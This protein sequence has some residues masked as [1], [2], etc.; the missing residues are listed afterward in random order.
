MIGIVMSGG[1][2]RGGHTVGALEYM[3]EVGVIPGDHAA[4]VGG[5]SHGALAAASLGQFRSFKEGVAYL[6][7]THE[8]LTGT[9]SI[10]RYR[11]P[12]GIPS[13]WNPSVGIAE[14]A[15][16]MIRERIQPK[17]FEDSGVHV[18]C[19]AVDLLSGKLVTY[20]NRRDWKPYY[21]SASFP[22]FFE[23]ISIGEYWLTDGGLR[24]V[25][26]LGA[27]IAAGCTT[28]YVLTC[29]HPDGV[30]RLTRKELRSAP[31]VAMRCVEIM[32]NEILHNDIKLCKRVNDDVRKGF[33]P[34]KRTVKLIEIYP[35]QPLGD[36]LDF[37]PDLFAQRRKLGY[38]D[39]RAAILDR[40]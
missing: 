35:S 13:L 18:H 26:P 37:S 23:P 15:R 40:S 10:W 9:K 7:E 33:R 38:Q 27:A 1:G 19:P 34:D 20:D 12:M 32:V 21:A 16:R 2:S 24:E 28:I 31:K 36:Q 4:Y 25:A 39:A 11:Q 30:E 14:A 3:V 6:A 29:S 5:T 8:S 17:R 22:V